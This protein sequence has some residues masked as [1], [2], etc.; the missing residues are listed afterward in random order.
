[1]GDVK[2]LHLFEDIAMKHSEWKCFI[3]RMGKCGIINDDF[4]F[5][6]QQYGWL[7]LISR[8]NMSRSLLIVWST[9]TGITIIW[10][11]CVKIE[12]EASI[13]EMLGYPNSRQTHIYIYIHIANIMPPL[14]KKCVWYWNYSYCGLIYAMQKCIIT[15]LWTP[16]KKTKKHSM[17]IEVVSCLAN[18]PAQDC[19]NTNLNECFQVM[20]RSVFSLHSWYAWFMCYVL[21]SGFRV[22]QVRCC[23]IDVMSIV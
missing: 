14:K 5:Y 13:H 19:L 4:W 12:D 11:V 23:Y 17:H 18:H 16:L 6:I 9:E 2:L 22:F 1:M 15:W 7:N 20:Y 10:C 21:S 3:L 8:V